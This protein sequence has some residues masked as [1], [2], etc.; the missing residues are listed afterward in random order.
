MKLML[1]PL[2]GHILRQARPNDIYHGKP[3]NMYHNLVC[4]LVESVSDV[5]SVA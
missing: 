1:T 3:G 2:S 4:V 5:L